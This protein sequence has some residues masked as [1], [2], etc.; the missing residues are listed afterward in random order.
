MHVHSRDK[1]SESRRTTLGT[2]PTADATTLSKPLVETTLCKLPSFARAVGCSHQPQ[3]EWWCPLAEVTDRVI[4]TPFK[5]RPPAACK[6]CYNCYIPILSSAS[7]SQRVTLCVKETFLGYRV[8]VRCSENIFLFCPKRLPA[9]P[10][11]R[12]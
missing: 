5:R 3:F 11:Q 10:P 12:F 9:A 6:M 7:R 4:I 2:Y 1:C 8:H